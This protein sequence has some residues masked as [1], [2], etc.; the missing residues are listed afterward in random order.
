[1]QWIQK[2]PRA[3]MEM[4]GF[5]PMFLNER[6]PRPAREQMNSNY[7]HGGGWRPLQGFKMLSNGNLKYP[8]DPEYLLLF[9]TKLRN[10]TIRFYT[11]EWLAIIQEDGSFEAS[12]VN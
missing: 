4:L 9:E 5:I 8:G 11:S 12:R 3:N 6:D 1:M 7:S 10:E 2:H